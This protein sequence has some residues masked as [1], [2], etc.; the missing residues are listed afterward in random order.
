MRVCDTVGDF[1]SRELK[2]RFRTLR[3]KIGVT[4]EVFA[5]RSGLDRVEVSNLESG[6]NQATSVRMLKGIAAGF[7]LSLQEA[8]DFIDGALDVDA[9]FQRIHAPKKM[10][11]ARELAADLARQIGVSE[12]AIRDVLDAPIP[13][14]RATWPALWWADAM[15]RREL[16][17]LPSTPK[18]G[19]G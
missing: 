17:M 18:K 4:Q 5:E 7:G 10:P 14:E 19:K 16:E 9:A 15:R 1:V 3:K 2:D 11:S 8:A 6:R 12:R 13:P